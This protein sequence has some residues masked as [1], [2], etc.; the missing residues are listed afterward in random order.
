MTGKEKRDAQKQFLHLVA[1]STQPIEDIIDTVDILPET[2]LNWMDERDFKSKLHGMRRF[3][4]KARD[5]QL[6]A[7]SLRAARILADLTT[8]SKKDVNKPNV[9]AACVDV[10]R[11]A[12]DSRA[13]R[14]SQDADET[15]RQ[16]RL[17]HPDL[18]DT[19]ATALLN[20][21]NASQDQEKPG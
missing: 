11:L 18:S 1:N 4:R 10:I 7:S 14:R 12:R 3:L 21:L 2:L 5:L 15:L 6:E 8:P 20:E 16:R 19:E 17:S 13:R 9:R